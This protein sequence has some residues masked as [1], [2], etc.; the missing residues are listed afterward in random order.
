MTHRILPPAEWVRLE[1]TPLG[2]ELGKLA[3]GAPGLTVFVVEDKDGHIVGHWSAFVAL[4]GEQVW[5]HPADRKRGVVVRHLLRAQAEF[6]ATLGATHYITH[7]A[8][9]EV[10]RLLDTLG[11]ARLPGDPYSVPV[12][13][14]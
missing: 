13:K 8:S 6:A 10:S 3:L 7:S 2:Q 11:A 4:H 9:A 1:G 5:V 12:R 14:E